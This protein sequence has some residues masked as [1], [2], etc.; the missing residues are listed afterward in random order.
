MLKTQL[1]ELIENHLFINSH[2][3]ETVSK[4]LSRFGLIAKSHYISHHDEINLL[5]FASVTSPPNYSYCLKYCEWIYSNKHFIFEALKPLNDLESLEAIRYI[6]YS[7][8][9]SIYECGLNTQTIVNNSL[10][11]NEIKSHTLEASKVLTI[12]KQV[13]VWRQKV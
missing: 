10:D 3:I 2:K 12:L 6:T 13:E 7:K 1:R 9:V 5:I 4:C 8:N 11:P